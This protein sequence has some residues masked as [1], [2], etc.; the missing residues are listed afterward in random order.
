M[1]STGVF[2]A[3]GR[4]PRLSDK[5][6]ATIRDTILSGR[7]RSGD[8]LPSERELGEQFGV[9]RTVIREAI[10]ALEANGL[11]EVR[12]GSGMRVA[13]VDSSAVRESIRRVVHASERS[14]A[15]VAEVRAVLEIV[16]ARLAAERATAEDITRL[17]LAVDQLARSLDDAEKAALADLE[18]RRAV[19]A[20]THNE[21]LVDLLDCLREAPGLDHSE[22]GDVDGSERAGVL[23]AHRRVFAALARGDA[24][25]AQAAVLPVKAGRELSA[26]KPTSPSAETM[27]PS[28]K[29]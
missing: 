14:H 25:A 24:E 18:F 16:A 10:R 2:E 8:L 7:L 29:P 23:E 17:E 28:P 20:A 3:I 26:Q 11:L 6:A 4:E 9:S 19:A 15:S 13:A 21:L 1:D 12:P 27:R 5:V 22:M